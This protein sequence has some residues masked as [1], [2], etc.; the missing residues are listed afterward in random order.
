MMPTY[1]YHYNTY[2]EAMKAVDVAV[3]ETLSDNPHLKAQEDD[4]F[5]D[6][7]QAIMPD[8]TPEVEA[9]LSQRTG[10]PRT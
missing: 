6:I 2:E 4:I 3:E 5:H 8:C 9:E 7:V 10:V 1:E